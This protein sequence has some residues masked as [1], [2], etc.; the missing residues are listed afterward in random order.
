ML[1]DVPK[2]IRRR[3][4][5]ALWAVGTLS[6]LIACGGDA[7]AP[8]VGRS[9]S[10]AEQLRHVLS[11]IGQR[12]PGFSERTS[13]S[14]RDQLFLEAAL[15]EVSSELAQRATLGTLTDV[16]LSPHA[17]LVATPHLLG[18]FDEKAEMSLGPSADP[19]AGATLSRWGM[20]ARHVDDGLSILEL[21]LELTSLLD[22]RVVTRTLQF[23][24][25]AR[26]NEPALARVVEDRARGQSLLVAFRS[27]RVRTELDLRAIFECKM[28]QRPPV[29]SLAGSIRLE[30]ENRN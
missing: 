11:A 10:D 25:T 12:C 23:S 6:M 28:R 17:R 16:A 15:V 14:D 29:A 24:T 30:R 5:R 1:F 27:F 22:H 9:S 19:S 8:A 26:P 7:L 2:S 21:E 3:D 13:A 18:T 20:V 4:H